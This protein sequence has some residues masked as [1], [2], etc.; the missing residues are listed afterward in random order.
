MIQI[1]LNHQCYTEFSDFKLW[2]SD[3]KDELMLTIIFLSGKK[4]TRPFH[5]W[6]VIPTIKLE[7]NLLYHKT[8]KMVNIID[9]A[10][11]VGEKYIL[12]K[13]PNSD[14]Q[15]VLY[16]NDVIISNSTNLK[17]SNLFHYF[18]NIAK[19]R[20]ENAHD[21]KSNV[22][23]NNI[24]EQFQNLL[25]FKDTALQAYIS[26]KAES[27]Q[28]ADDLIFPF[29]VNETQLAAVKY[30][31]QSQVSIIEGPPGTGKT[32][33]IL[34]IIA[35]IL[36]K[37]K[38][39]AVVSNNNSAVENV[40]EKLQGVNLD[41]LIAKLGSSSKK[42]TFFQSNPNWI[43]DCTVSDINLDLINKKVNDIEKYLSLK[44]R[45]AELECQLKEIEIE[46]TYLENWYQTS[47]VIS[48]HIVEKYKLSSQKVLELF[49]YLRQLSNK[50]LSFKDKMRLLFNYHIFKNKPFNDPSIRQEIIYALQK[51]YYE[52]LSLEIHIE[53]SDID[54]KLLSAKYDDLLKELTE[55]SMKYL[56]HY[57][58][59]NIPKDKPSF[60]VM[61][62]KK[63]FKSFI[64]HFPIIG[65]STHSLV[66]SIA[67]G[68]ILDYVIVDE[69]SQQDIVPGV[70]CLGCAKNVVIVGD[71]KQLPH[72]PAKSN[73]TAPNM[74]YDCCK[75]SLL[76]SICEVFQDQIPRT[77]LK[78]HYR[79]HPKI[80]Q[81]CNK[82][83]Y[84]NELIPMTKD[85]EEDSIQ[86]IITAKGNHM[87]QYKNQREIDSILKVKETM[88]FLDNNTGFIAP[89]N[90]QVNLAR[91][92]LPTEVVKDTI[93]KFQGRECDKIIF[94]T[95]LDKKSE[96]RMQIDFVDNGP[97]INVAVSRAKKQFCLVTGK[98]VFK[99]NNK[100]IAALIRYIEY[101][102]S[103]KE[104]IIDSPVISAF[105]LLYAEYDRSLEKL[106]KKLNKKDSRY[107][108]EQIVS[109]LVK[110][111]LDDVKYD[112]LM[113]HKQVYLRQ[114]VNETQSDFNN[115][116]LSFMKNGASCDFVV[117]YKIGKKPIAV[118]E[119]DGGSHLKD[120]QMERDSVKDE[121]LKKANISLLRLP[122]TASDIEGKLKH[123]IDDLLF[124]TY[125]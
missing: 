70:L 42:E 21:E 19:E 109:A 64:R 28:D 13:Y 82:Q 45:S 1:Y 33:T 124:T 100:Y 46:K 75:Y 56:K 29:G 123:F 24:V 73:L 43:E 32:Q 80:I 6:N 16:A 104:D 14:K 52:K 58:F 26:Q 12:A 5:E 68:S 86:L 118:I 34:N 92:E 119:V 7:G 88:G 44:N 76:D 79:C 10:Y 60:T 87:R 22:I 51:E 81:F 62:Y 23:A 84:H 36:I 49:T 59:K 107:K 15:Y 117:Y 61:N 53:K 74:L 40:Y 78:E 98:D 110:D 3:Q 103:K 11:E 55:E 8:N 31:F 101:Y 48:T 105:D 39:C 85:Q 41:F 91:L 90:N 20:V 18:V 27:F 116:E 121:I 66:N 106:N 113:L 54:K 17:E 37:G 9:E 97:L 4:Y 25:P 35:N 71:R 102:S 89:Y 69:A 57:L 122:T 112:S 115:R 125:N 47:G 83:F 99:T 38:T 95:V 67:K 111:L 50:F 93:H 94:S 63:H 77:L 108:S 96:S 2:F 114:L 30:A 72:I 65:S 120:D